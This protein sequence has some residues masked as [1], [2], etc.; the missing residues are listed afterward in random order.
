MQTTGVPKFSN[1]TVTHKWPSDLPDSTEYL[2]KGDGRK[3]QAGMLK[4]PEPVCGPPK[5]DA[6]KPRDN[7]PNSQ[8]RKFY[9]RGDLPVAVEH[10]VRRKAEEC[11]LNGVRSSSLNGVQVDAAPHSSVHC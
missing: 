5:A 11:S 6:F 4:K 7:P 10:K 3:I 9:E 8:F 2:R 1:P